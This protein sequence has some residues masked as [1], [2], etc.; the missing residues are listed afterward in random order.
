MQTTTTTKGAVSEY[1]SAAW[2]SE[3]GF[4]IFWTPSG[5]G[6]CDFIAIRGSESQRVQVKTAHWCQQ[7]GSR[8]LRGPVQPRKG[9]YKD[10]DYDLLAI[11]CPDRRVWIIPYKEVPETYYIYLERINKH[12]DTK[13]YGWKKC[14]VI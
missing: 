9:Q 12:G 10:G 11:V 7:G 3:Q 6:P 8:Y 4:E 1:R 13:E 2:F 5:A 14:Q